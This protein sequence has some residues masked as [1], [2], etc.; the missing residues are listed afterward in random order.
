MARGDEGLEDAV[1]GEP[2]CDFRAGGGG[3]CGGGREV[4]GVEGDGGEGDDEEV[5]ARGGEFGKDREDCGTGVGGVVDCGGGG[6]VE[7][8]HYPRT[9]SVSPRSSI[10]GVWEKARRT[11]DVVFVAIFL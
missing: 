4:V 1:G 2:G 6:E 10:W 8:F 7:K 5:D 9:P 3:V 11:G